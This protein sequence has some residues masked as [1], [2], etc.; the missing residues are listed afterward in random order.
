[1]STSTGPAR[2]SARRTA[3][4]LATLAVVALVLWRAADQLSGQ[5]DEVR[6]R[7]GSL[8]P[9][10]PLVLASAALVLAT[11]ALL[12]HAWR[13]LVA[14]W[15]SRLAFWPASRI[16]AVSNLG[17]YLPGKVWSIAAMGLLSRQ[18]GVSAGAASGAA[19]AGTLVNLAA[20][21]AVMLLAGLPVLRSVAP[22]GAGAAVAIAV[23]ATI[24]LVLLPVALTPA[25][26]LMARLLK[27][28][29]PVRDAPARV[30]WLVVLS[31]VAAW[32][33]YGVAFRLLALSLAPASAGNWLEYVAVFTG[34]YLA[35]YLALVIP[36]GI[37]V[38]EVAMVSS[39]TALGLTTPVEAWLLAFVSR[40]WLTVLEVAPGLLFLA[41]DASLRFPPSRTDVP[42]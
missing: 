38:R 36:G 12:V 24:G 37:G 26:R 40:L 13:T 27:R 30:L 42:S 35:G 15:G 41:R 17:R 19:V 34:S 31:N 1:M 3:I 21:F 8:R 29:V 4:W 28:E 18:A 16:W 6:M 32:V 11:Y 2:A 39:L 22:G 9:E 10:W 23:A 33:G 25:L 14:A 5:W 20:G 7:A